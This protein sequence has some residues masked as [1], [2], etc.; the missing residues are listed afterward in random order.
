[1]RRA[2]RRILKFEDDLSHRHHPPHDYNSRQAPPTSAPINLPTT[3]S[4]VTPQQLYAMQ[5]LSM[6]PQMMQMA[7]YPPSQ[8][9]QPSQGQLPQG[10]MPTQGT[11][12]GSYPPY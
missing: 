3:M 1:M 12:T 5:L 11:T 4:S 9:N 10:Q 8:P 7:G 2:G 6:N